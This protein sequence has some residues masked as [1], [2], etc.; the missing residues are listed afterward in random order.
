MS[1]S[2]FEIKANKRTRGGHNQASKH[3]IANTTLEQN[4]FWHRSLPDRNYLPA[5]TIKSKA[6]AELKSELGDYVCQPFLPSGLILHN[7]E[8]LEYLLKVKVKNIKKTT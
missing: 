1:Y 3:I 7:G 4:S 2:K 6:V 8:L 5:T